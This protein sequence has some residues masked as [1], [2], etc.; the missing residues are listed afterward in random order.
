MSRELLQIK[1]I[2]LGDN[3]RINQTEENIICDLQGRR[4]ESSLR[5]LPTHRSVI[6]ESEFILGN[7]QN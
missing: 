1:N 7:N 5:V 3:K 2:E 4:N 6:V